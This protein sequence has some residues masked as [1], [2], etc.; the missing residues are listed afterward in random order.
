[1]VEGCT[2]AVGAITVVKDCAFKYDNTEKHKTQESI[3]L[4]IFFMGSMLTCLIRLQGKK[5]STIAILS[6]NF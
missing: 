3:A 2:D 1:M 6:G 4:P 5:K